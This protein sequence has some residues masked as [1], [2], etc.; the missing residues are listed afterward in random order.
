[1]RSAP[2]IAA[3]AALLLTGCPSTEARESD[4]P[5]GSR[6]PPDITAEDYVPPPLPRGTVLLEDAYGG[7]RRVQVEVAATPEART[8]GLM[9]R[10]DLPQG[11]GMLFVFPQ[12]EVHAFWMVN[13]L[14]PLDMVFIDAQGRIV[15]IVERAPPHSMT[16]RSVDRP[17]RSVLEVPGGWAQAAG[18]RPGGR[19]RF[20]GIPGLAHKP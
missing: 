13:T 18:L 15:G 19:V 7:V 5:G 4:G 3:L 14:I 20:E 8:R 2:L 16:A 6:A 17:S 10:K 12:E 9:W 1:M 11:Q